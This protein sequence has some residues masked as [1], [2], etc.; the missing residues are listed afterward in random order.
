MTE[1]SGLEVNVQRGYFS[2]VARSECVLITKQ[3]VRTGHR[4][5]LS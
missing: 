2:V 1:L 4:A 3:S 5:V